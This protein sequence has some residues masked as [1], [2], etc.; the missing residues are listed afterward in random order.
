MR[1]LVSELVRR[2]IVASAGGLAGETFQRLIGSDHKPQSM[3]ID[4]TLGLAG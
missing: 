3:G 4:R 1:R 2:F